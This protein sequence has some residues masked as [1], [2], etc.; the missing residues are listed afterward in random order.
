MHQ[1]GTRDA[2]GSSSGGKGARRHSRH[3]KEQ[4]REKAFRFT[5]RADW[6]VNLPAGKHSPCHLSCPCSK[7]IPKKAILILSPQPVSGLIGK[8][9]TQSR[10]IKIIWQFLT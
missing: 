2:D 6:E 7:A 9:K 3:P 8:M 10:A 1:A 5:P 4:E